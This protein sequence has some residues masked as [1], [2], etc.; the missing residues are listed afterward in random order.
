MILLHFRQ[1]LLVI[2][3]SLFSLKKPSESPSSL[4][5][6]LFQDQLLTVQTLI[7]SLFTCTLIGFDALT[8]P[9]SSESLPGPP[10]TLEIP[11]SHDPPWHLIMSLCPSDQTAA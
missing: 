5:F 1:G 6:F 7:L 2:G 10:Q 4:G 8:D 9:G 3:L 11:L